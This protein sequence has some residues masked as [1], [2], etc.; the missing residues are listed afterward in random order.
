MK[1]DVFIQL[2]NDRTC[3]GC[4][5]CANKCPRDCIDMLHDREGFFHPVIDERKCIRCG[6]CMAVCRLLEQCPCNEVGSVSL[7][8]A[9]DFETQKDSSSGGVFYVLARQYIENGHYIAGAVWEDGLNV[10]HIVTN[11][12]EDLERMRK[13]KYIQSETGFIY[14]EIEHL[15][16]SGKKILFSGTS[17]QVAGLKAFLQR[18]YQ[19]LLCIGLIC[20]GVSSGKLLEKHIRSL[21]DEEIEQVDFR[22][23]EKI[24]TGIGLYIRCKSGKEIIKRGFSQ[25]TFVYEYCMGMNYRKCCYDCC[26]RNRFP[27]DL[28]IGDAGQIH[29]STLKN[30]MMERSVAF[31]LNGKGREVLFDIIGQFRFVGHSTIEEIVSGH[32][33]SLLSSETGNAELRDQFYQST[34]NSESPRFDILLVVLWAP[35]YGTYLTN[36]ALHNAIKKMGKSILVLSHSGNGV[37]DYCGS[38]L[39]EKGRDFLASNMELSYR[40]IET[41]DISQIADSAV[42]GSDILWNRSI[43]RDYPS[44]QVYS[45]S[46]LHPKVKRISYGVSI[47]TKNGFPK[48]REKVFKEAIRLFTHVSL[49]EESGAAWIRENFCKEADTVLDPVFLTKKADYLR[50]CIG[51]EIKRKPEILLY[52]LNLNEFW[53]DYIHELQKK[54]SKSIM[55]ILGWQYMEE[56]E[57][58]LTRYGLK[59]LALPVLSIP[60]W[61]WYFS[62]AEYVMTDSWHGACFGV[63]FEKRILVHMNQMQERFSTLYQIEELRNQFILYSNGIENDILQMEKCINYKKVR[64]KISVE[65]ERSKKWLERAIKDSHAV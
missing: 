48:E 41:A 58:E 5:A 12:D 4:G 64:K 34:F 29:V 39:P 38:L 3:T 14:R 25:D 40:Y 24:G 16:K 26:Y 1:K 28:L 59:D 44:F 11:E 32:N 30:D 17:C 61:I 7:N 23:R 6:E 35:N 19:N 37:P 46:W 10:R 33:R 36:F 52:I 15:L 55:L 63:L 27:C 60:E 8:L 42:L 51:M 53:A 62:N 65:I 57:N 45:L 9:A 49:R 22:N 50:L 31:A 21:T 56:H 47:G 43:M 13:S 18:D 2:A 20:R 54:T